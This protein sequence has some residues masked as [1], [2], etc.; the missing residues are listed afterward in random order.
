MMHR[1]FRGSDIA[2]L[3]ELALLGPFVRLDEYL[4]IHRDHAD[5]YYRTAD[6]DPNAVTAWYD[7]K[8]RAGTWHKWALYGS[9]LAAIGRQPLSRLERVRCYGQ[10]ARSASMWVNLKGLARDVGWAIDPRLVSLERR[11][12][13]GLFGAPKL[14]AGFATEGNVEAPMEQGRERAGGTP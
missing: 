9:H 10:V 5:R 6:P 7:P 14:P 4:F 8:Q 3:A 13:R 11:V 12:S 1:P 2:I